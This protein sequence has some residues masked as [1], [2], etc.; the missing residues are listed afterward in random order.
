MRELAEICEL[1]ERAE[2]PVDES[3]ATPEEQY[4]WHDLRMRR[5]ANL[6]RPGRD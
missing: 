2:Y 4:F 3:D 5:L 1:N 6:K